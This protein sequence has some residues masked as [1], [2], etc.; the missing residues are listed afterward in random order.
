MLENG[1]TLLERL[2]NRVEKDEI[3]GC[4]EWTGAKGIDGYGRIGDDKKVKLTHRVAYEIMRGPLHRGQVIDHLCR[5]R[6]CVNPDHMEATSQ[7]INT[8]RGNTADIRK[9][10]AAQQTHCINGHEFTKENIYLA[11]NQRYCRICKSI[12]YKR[13]EVRKKV[14]IKVETNAT[15][16]HCKQGHEL[17]GDN[18][19][20]VPRN[21][22]DPNSPMRRV[23]RRCKADAQMRSQ[24]RKQGQL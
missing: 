20:V 4:W 5:N 15:K 9:K 17:S 24:A 14:G 21:A 16:T 11:N 10:L 13:W 3:T 6:L 8:I 2:F 22:S 12:R 23:C 18:V 19:G 1:K 7:R